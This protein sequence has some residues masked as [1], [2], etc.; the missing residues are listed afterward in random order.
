[1]SPAVERG[2]HVGISACDVVPVS[3]PAKRRTGIIATM[4]SIR[5]SLLHCCRALGLS[6]VFVVGIAAAQGGGKTPPTTP[7]PPAPA[8]Q[9]SPLPQGDPAKVHAND[10]FANY[11][12]ALAAPRGERPGLSYVALGGGRADIALKPFHQFDCVL[13]AGSAALK[14]V[15]WRVATL[16]KPDVTAAEGEWKGIDDLAAGEK[17]ELTQRQNWPNFTGWRID[18]EWK[19]GAERFVAAS[20]AMLPIPESALADAPF[21][22]VAAQDWDPSGKRLSLS[23]TLWNIGGRPATGLVQTIRLLDD[24]CRQLQEHEHKV[25]AAVP[26]RGTLDQKHD[27]DQVPVFGIGVITAVLPITD[28]PLAGAAGYG[29]AVPDRAKPRLRNTT[30]GSIEQVT[31]RLDAGAVPVRLGTLAASEERD[32]P[33]LPSK[34]ASWSGVLRLPGVPAAVRGSLTP[35]L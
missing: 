1:M 24:R 8:P 18:V 19:G 33:G 32:L 23:W 25:V 28:A 35:G 31:V 17:R 14:N 27:L 4:P 26:P 2:Y 29:V 21:V 10:A 6:S 12:L 20:K 13:H 5:S 22:V 30:A 16:A 9:K 34:N 15:R 11:C 3:L 7:K